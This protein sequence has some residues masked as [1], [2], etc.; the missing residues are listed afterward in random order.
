MIHLCGAHG[1]HI[2]VWREM[3]SLRAVQ[4]NDQ[5]AGDLERYFEGLRKDQV[6]YVNPCE[7][8]PVSRIMEITRGY[9][10]AIVADIDPGELTEHSVEAHV[11]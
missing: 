8:M 10:T 1:Q 7:D 6:I 2:P 4:L 9:R 11:C 5:A 3:Q